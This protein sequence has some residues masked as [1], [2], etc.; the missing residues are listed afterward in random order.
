MV[1]GTHK[2]RKEAHGASRMIGPGSE[3]AKRF[4]VEISENFVS[5][6][7]KNN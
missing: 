5:V 3:P 4:Q 1:N 2:T 6:Y 7:L